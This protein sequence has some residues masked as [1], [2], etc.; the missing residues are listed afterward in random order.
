MHINEVYQL[1]LTLEKTQAKRESIKEA[2][3]TRVC[4]YIFIYMYVCVWGGGGVST[5]LFKTVPLNV[6]VLVVPYIL[7]VRN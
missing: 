5:I 7:C 3:H 6:S 2:T 1:P 4:M